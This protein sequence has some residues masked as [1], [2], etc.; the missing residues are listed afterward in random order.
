MEQIVNHVKH[1]KREIVPHKQDCVTQGVFINALIEKEQA[2]L[3]GEQGAQDQ[4]GDQTEGCQDCAYGQT[5]AKLVVLVPADT[6]GGIVAH[7]HRSAL[8]HTGVNI[9]YFYYD[10]V[11]GSCGGADGIDIWK[12]RRT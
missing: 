4:Q 7:R 8:I 2:D 11:C 6:L 1:Q 9:E 12:Y 10:C 5:F 3:S